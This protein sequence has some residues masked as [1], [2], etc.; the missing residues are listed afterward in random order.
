MSFS[1]DAKRLEQSFLTT[2]DLLQQLLRALEERRA[3]WVSVRPEVLAP[4]SDV[5]TLSQRLA[6][7]EDGR[8]ELIRRM[9][10]ALPTP[11]GIDPSKVNVNVTRIAGALP[12]EQGRA[13]RAASDAVQPLARRVRSEVTLGQRLLRFA[14]N[15]QTSAEQSLAGAARA[16]QTPVYDRRARNVAKNGAAGQLVDGRI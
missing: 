11:P 14:K 1:E 4:S 15:A 12:R 16:T 13:L 5:E 3:A 8:N 7:E 9:R 10:A 2:K 6:L